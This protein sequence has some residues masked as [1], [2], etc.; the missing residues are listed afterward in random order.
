MPQS[1]KEIPD[2]IIPREARPLTVLQIYCL[3]MIKIGVRAPLSI[4]GQ[5]VSASDCRPAGFQNSLN[6]AS[7]KH[8]GADCVYKCAWL[9]C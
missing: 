4:S 2:R 5:I 1:I 8:T 3:T 7:F 6:Q 9:G